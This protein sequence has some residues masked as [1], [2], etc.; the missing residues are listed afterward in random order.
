VTVV[1]DVDIDDA[2]GRTE[3]IEQRVGGIHPDVADRDLVVGPLDEVGDGRRSHL[4]GA[5]QG[6]DASHGPIVAWRM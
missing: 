2:I 5:A 6:Q 1:V 3:S 4:T